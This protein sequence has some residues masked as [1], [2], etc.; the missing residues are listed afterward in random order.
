MSHFQVVA[1]RYDDRVRDGGVPGNGGTRLRH[2]CARLSGG[3]PGY[4]L[5]VKIS[6]GGAVESHSVGETAL[7]TPLPTPEP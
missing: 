1:R 4:F 6:P 7:V 2:C 3:E 5:E